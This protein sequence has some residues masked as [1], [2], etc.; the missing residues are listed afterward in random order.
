VRCNAALQAPGARRPVV[1]LGSQRWAVIVLSACSEAEEPLPAS[2]LGDEENHLGLQEEDLR[3]SGDGADDDGVMIAH[4]IDGAAEKN[5][6]MELV[7]ALAADA[8]TPSSGAGDKR[9]FANDE[10]HNTS[11]GALGA[12]VDDFMNGSSESFAIEAQ[13]DGECRGERE[14]SNADTEPGSELGD[15]GDDIQGEDAKANGAPAGRAC[16]HDSIG[17]RREASAGAAAARTASG[18]SAASPRCLPSPAIPPPIPPSCPELTVLSLICFRRV[19]I[20][21]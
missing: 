4:L 12:D 7:A 15:L 17:L 14:A 21:A 10:A 18:A 2:Y 6:D 1:A 8:M 11:D 19:F 16:Q 9:S 3:G 20:L 13:Q 5:M